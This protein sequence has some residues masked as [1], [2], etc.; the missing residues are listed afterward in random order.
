P[1]R[2]RSHPRDVAEA[3]AAEGDEQHPHRAVVV[4]HGFTLFERGPAAG[5]G[6]RRGRT[7]VRGSAGGAPSVR[8]R[9]GRGGDRASEPAEKSSIDE[10]GSPPPVP[11]L[12]HA[13][14]AVRLASWTT[15]VGKRSQQNSP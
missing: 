13:A 5:T 9:R 7:T 15:P 11:S 1:L 6:T 8:W 14:P 3:R 4:V 10:L 2:G 12:V